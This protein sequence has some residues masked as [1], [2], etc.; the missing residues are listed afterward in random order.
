MSNSY[1]TYLGANRCCNLKGGGML[2]PQGPLGRRGPIGP[3]GPSG[4]TGPTG[5]QSL[6]LYPQGTEVTKSFESS[7]TTRALAPSFTDLL[8][9]PTIGNTSYEY[10]PTIVG[11][12]VITYPNPNY[13]S[14]D[15]QFATPEGVLF[16]N[17]FPSGVYYASVTFS[18]S[19][20]NVLGVKWIL[21]SASYDN[22]IGTSKPPII[23]APS[24]GPCGCAK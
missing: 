3:A 10:T 22:Y 13:I 7:R 12:N 16:F 11:D 15:P 18:A 20:A 4:P 2:G 9:T 23:G 8:F 5:E 17:I 6:L 24:Y 21:Y 14:P 1:S 19:I